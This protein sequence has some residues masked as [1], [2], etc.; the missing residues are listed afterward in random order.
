[1]RIHR[2]H[3][4]EQKDCT[5][6]LHSGGISRWS[7]WFRRSMSPR[8]FHNGPSV[9]IGLLVHESSTLPLRNRP[10]CRGGI[11]HLA[12]VESSTLPWWNRLPYPGGIVHLW[13][14]RPPLVESS[15]SGGIV[16]LALM[17]LSTSGGIVHLALVESSTLPWWNRP[18]SP[19]GI[20]NLSW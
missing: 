7:M 2:V 8:N 14:N 9:Q 5:A 13:W 12:M 16:H 11:V 20:V 15:T 3:Y 19:G 1:M 6:G 4:I 17:E 18:P 10:P